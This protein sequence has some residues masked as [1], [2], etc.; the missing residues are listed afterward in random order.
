MWGE[1][2]QIPYT[3]WSKK[4]HLT[5][6]LL[7]FPEN[8][9]IV[10]YSMYFSTLWLCSNL[11]HFDKK[12]CTLLRKNSSFRIQENITVRSAGTKGLSTLGLSTA[13]GPKGVGG[14][15]SF[16]ISDILSLWR[17]S[18]SWKTRRI[19]RENGINAKSWIHDA[20]FKSDKVNFSKDKKCV[21][22]YSPSEIFAKSIEKVVVP[23]E[24]FRKLR[25]KI[26]Q[27][28]WKS[29]ID[30]NLSKN[31][32]FLTRIFVAEILVNSKK[33]KVQKFVN[34]CQIFWQWREKIVKI[35]EI[36]MKSYKPCQMIVF[37]F[38]T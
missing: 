18:R 7:I 28:K 10:F 14:S 30:R 31:L 21:K 27:I 23:W 8:V 20:I 32:P 35:K 36:A 3:L 37:N 24:M 33:L 1:N 12:F 16:G 9:V 17:G 22:S 25:G 15:Q 38:S 4:S 5:E 6:K 29:T 26:D 19:F 2:S 13:E 34:S 11:K